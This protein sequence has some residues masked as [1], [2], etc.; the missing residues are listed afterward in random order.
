MRHQPYQRIR[1]SFRDFALEP[2]QLR[3]LEGVAW[4]VTEKI[5]GANFCVMCDGP[6]I[7]C[8]KRREPIVE[9]DHFFG[10]REVVAPLR[11]A[12]LTIS[13]D[14]RELLVAWLREEGRDLLMA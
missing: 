3:A 14:E 10:F 1:S 4:I 9:A 2:G 8:A 6:H 11:P 7:E 12:L 5:H 13:V